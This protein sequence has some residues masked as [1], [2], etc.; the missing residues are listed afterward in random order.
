MLSPLEGIHVQHIKRLT[1][2]PAFVVGLTGL[3]APAIADTS[4]L[5]E[6][7]VTALAVEHCQPDAEAPLS[8]EALAPV[9][10]GTADVEVVPGEISAHILRFAV[11]VGEPAECTVGVLHR[12]TALAQVVYEGTAVVGGTETLIELGNMGKSAPVDPTTEISLPGSLL[13]TADAVADPAYEFALVR[14]S[15]QTVLIAV[16]RAQKDAAGR[17]LKS[18]TKAAAHLLR[19]QQKAAGKGKGAAKALAS[20]QRNYDRKVAAAQARYTK[21]VTPKTVTRPVGVSYNV[22]GTVAR[23][24]V[25]PE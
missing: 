16:D 22:S 9:V 10:I 3:T 2:V 13:L 8:A 7:A 4:P 6:D 20:A 15:L 21:A 12:E 25:A 11:D 17:L 19:Q 5:A 18:E 23:T 1:L 24:E 14:K